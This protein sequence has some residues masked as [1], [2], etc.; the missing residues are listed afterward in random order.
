[1]K[2]TTA[3]L[4]CFLSFQLLS[5]QSE[6]RAE[7]LQVVKTASLDTAKLEALWQLGDDF[8]TDQLDSARL[9]ITQGL[10]LAKKVKEPDWEA[11]FLFTMGKL[12]KQ[13]GNYPQAID[14]YLQAKTIWDKT[15]NRGG[16]ANAELFIGEV[17]AYQDNCNLSLAYYNKARAVYQEAGHG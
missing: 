2:K 10:T 9:Y 14:N 16:A 1:M 17:Y 5:A 8:I 15:G 6:R 4:L 3:I 13:Q 11:Q 7:L 12:F